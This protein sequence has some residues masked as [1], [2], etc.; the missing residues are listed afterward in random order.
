MIIKHYKTKSEAEANCPAGHKLI[1][2]GN[3][4]RR[5]R[6]VTDEEYGQLIASGKKSLLGS[7]TQTRSGHFL[8]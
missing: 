6:V 2:E 1:L 7:D 4:I 8:Q 3:A 5:W